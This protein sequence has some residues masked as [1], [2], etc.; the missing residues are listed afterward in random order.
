MYKCS[1]QLQ[2]VSTF[3]VISV[4]QQ[5]SQQ[6]STLCT[7]NLMGITGLFSPVFPVFPS[8]WVCMYPHF[9]QWVWA[10]PCQPQFLTNPGLAT[11]S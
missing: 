4:S 8:G 10:P 3:H 2:S 9:P 1:L 5:S 7:Q 11:F 6:M